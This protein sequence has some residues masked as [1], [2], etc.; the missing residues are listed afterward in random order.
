MMRCIVHYYDQALKAIKESS[1]EH[2]ISWAVIYNS[3]K[4]LFDELMQM[5]F[6]DPKSDPKEFTEY[7]NKIVGDI[8]VAF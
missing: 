1:G 7:F 2:K 5:K 4:A 3:T 8:T 6:K